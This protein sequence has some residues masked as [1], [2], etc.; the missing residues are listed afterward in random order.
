MKARRS[1]QIVVGALA[2]TLAALLLLGTLVIGAMAVLPDMFGE[3]AQIPTQIST[4][5]KGIAESLGVAERYYLVAITAYAFPVLLLLLSALL[6]LLKRGKQ[7]Q[8]IAG[9]VLALLGGVI[10]CGFSAVFAKE[11][12]GSNAAALTG[13][14]V[15]VLALLVLFAGLALGLK[16]KKAVMASE[17]AEQPEAEPATEQPAP[18]ETEQPAPEDEQQEAPARPEEQ[19]A[20][21]EP[22]AEAPEPAEQEEATEEQPDIAEDVQNMY[23]PTNTSVQDTVEDIYGEGEAKSVPDSK[24][25]TLRMLLE[26]G[27]ISEEEYTKLLK[28]YLK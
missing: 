3:K 28:S 18:L 22:I 20:E 19:D 1:M 16:P 7:A 13:V 23:V 12:A 10:V 11:L 21:P 6:L 26:M 25:A 24:L 27:A 4:A 9:C 2:L 17:D 5:L 14:S 8:Y 15:F